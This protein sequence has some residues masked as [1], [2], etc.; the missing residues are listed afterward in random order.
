MGIKN[1]EASLSMKRFACFLILLIFHTGLHANDPW[2]GAAYKKHS[3]SQNSA[4]H[5]LLFHVNF[6]G[7]E[8]IIDV[9]CGDGRI[10]AELAQLVPEGEVIG[11]DNSSSMIAFA[12][13]NFD[14]QSWPNLHFE[15]MDACALSFGEQFD[16]V[17]TFSAA[18]WFE[19]QHSFLIGAKRSLRPKG[20]LVLSMPAEYPYPLQRAIHE[21]VVSKRWADYFV[22]FRSGQTFYDEPTYIRLIQEHG[23]SPIRVSWTWKQ[24]TFASEKA[25]KQFIAQ[26]LPFLHSIPQK[27]QDQ[28]MDELIERYLRI[29]PLDSQGQAHFAIHRLELIAQVV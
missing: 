22:D 19:D 29:E 2:N 25:L 13:S 23:F 17:V 6:Q 8:A 16:F 15:Q 14:A 24:E 9:G 3:S 5:D 18:Q 20:M 7:N 26:W 1:R 4:A 11:I 12:K 10:S 28:F 27:E 21:M